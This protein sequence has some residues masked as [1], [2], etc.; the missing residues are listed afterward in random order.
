L[1]R[2]R[3]DLFDEGEY[4]PVAVEGTKADHVIA[5]VRKAETGRVLVVVPH[6]VAGLLNDFDLPPLGPQVWEDTQVQLPECARPE[7]YQNAFTGE[8]IEPETTDGHTKIAVS[9]ILAKFPVALCL[10]ESSH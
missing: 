7:K 1:R 5:F 2:Q 8:V 4:L 10:L 6:L 9:E 3:P